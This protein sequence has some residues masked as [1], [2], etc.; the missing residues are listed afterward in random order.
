MN[1][2]IL[3]EW[4]ERI[5]IGLNFCPFA[6]I[7]YQNNLIEIS[8]CNESSEEE[9]R[10]F[11][12]DELDKIQKSSAIEISNSLVCFP[13]YKKDF[14]EFYD[15]VSYCEELIEELGLEQ[16]FQLVCFHPNFQFENTTPKER[17][18]LINSS[19]FALIHILRSQEVAQAL[20]SH[21]D[22][23]MISFRNEDKLNTLDQDD[24]M[25]LFPWWF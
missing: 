10:D 15:F 13:N 5:I 9:M 11:F 14:F 20:K 17:V 1:E 24:I 21:N 4:I 22:A 16:N 6:K 12:L 18:N 8:F 3:K 2:T 19:P 23:K 7:P 25:N